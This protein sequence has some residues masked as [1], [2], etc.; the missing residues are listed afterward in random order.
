MPGNHSDG[1]ESR[2][3]ARIRRK[4]REKQSVVRRCESVKAKLKREKN[5][6]TGE[7]NQWNQAYEVFRDNPVTAVVVISNLFEGECSGRIGRELPENAEIMMNT[8][9]EGNGLIEDL[10]E[11]IGRLQSCICQLED[12]I[13]DLYD[14][15]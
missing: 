1:A 9:R 10:E 13:S 12:E 11:Q 14:R 5:I 8:K 2:R 15:L 3:R 6:L 4:I 7:L